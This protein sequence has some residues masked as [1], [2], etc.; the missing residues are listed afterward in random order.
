MGYLHRFLDEMFSP[1]DET[2]P[3]PGFIEAVAVLLERPVQ[4][5]EAESYDGLMKLQREILTRYPVRIH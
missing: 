5:R 3:S 4:A 2:F 1:A